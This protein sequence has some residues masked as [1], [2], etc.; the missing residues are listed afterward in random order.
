MRLHV[1]DEAIPPVCSRSSARAT[2]AHHFAPTWLLAP[3]ARA[4]RHAHCTCDGGPKLSSFSWVLCRGG[5]LP[6]PRVLETP[7]PSPSEGRGPPLH[8]RPGLTPQA[9]PCPPSA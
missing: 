4:A 1:S 3:H 5:E 6:P 7:R 8:S 9:A 2:S